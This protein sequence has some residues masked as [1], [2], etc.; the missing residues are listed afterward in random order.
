MVNKKRWKLHWVFSTWS[1]FGDGTQQ[2]VVD[3]RCGVVRLLPAH[4][5]WGRRR[6]EELLLW[7]GRLQTRTSDVDRLEDTKAKFRFGDKLTEKRLY[8]MKANFSGVLFFTNYT[9]KKIK[10]CSWKMT[11]ILI[12]G[13][14]K[15]AIKTWIHQA[16]YSG[17]RH[18]AVR[19]VVVGRAN[20]YWFRRRTLI[21]NN[22]V[23]TFL[24]ETTQ[25]NKNTTQIQ[26]SGYLKC[27]NINLTSWSQTPTI[28]KAM[29]GKA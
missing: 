24:W 8:W 10:T 28:T 12:I 16:V 14:H 5:R 18:Q 6:D 9:I 21:F 17:W 13:F 3:N 2:V 19:F 26:Q 29:D 7:F 1:Q 25:T 23:W 20:R 4:R 22:S 27:N 15:N 11:W